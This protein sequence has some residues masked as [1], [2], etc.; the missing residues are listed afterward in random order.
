MGRN[1]HLWMYGHYGPPVVVFPSAAGFAHEW[2]HQGVVEALAPLLYAGKLKLYCTESNVSE[3]WTHS[4]ADPRWRMERHAAFERYVL[5]TLVP[6]VR[7]DCRSPQMRIAAAGA[8][9]GGLYAANMAL[10]HPETFWW[11]LCMSGRYEAR[12]FTGGYDAPEVYFNNPL[13]F[14]P[15]LGGAE[16]DRVRQ[17]A[18]TLVCGQGKW[19]EGCLEETVALGEVLR[20]K[21]IPAEVDLWGHDVAHDWEWWRRQAAYH[22]ARRLGE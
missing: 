11:S 20:S 21:G 9:L 7:D 15:Q 13:A 3:A 22:L 2:D 1:V 6:F 5:E 18:L 12:N 14:V 10:K 17:T 16:L 19:E 8:S 4:D